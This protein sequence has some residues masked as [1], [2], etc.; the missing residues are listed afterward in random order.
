MVLGNYSTILAQSDLGDVEAQY[1]SFSEKDIY[2]SLQKCD[3]ASLSSDG[4]SKADIQILRT[5]TY[6]DLLLERAKLPRETLQKYGHTDSEINQLKQFASSNVLSATSDSLARAAI[7]CSGSLSKVSASSTSIKVKY[8]WSWNARPV[9][10]GTDT[11][12]MRW[13][14]VRSDGTIISAS[15]TSKSAFVNYY[16]IDTGN[17]Y[18][19]SSFTPTSKTDFDAIYLEFNMQKSVGYWAKSGNMTAT[20]TKDGSSPLY[21]VKVA[22]VYGHSIL[23]S[24]A[25]ISYSAGGYSISI[26]PSSREE[27]SGYSNITVYANGTVITN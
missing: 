17:L 12:G 1:F 14:A 26:S 13:Q 9:F 22:A 21:L 15:A 20:I 2:E 16:S 18:T 7:A 4:F 25:S 8:S 19:T 11:V 5:K 24:K 6:N 10:L 23:N 3:N 27:S